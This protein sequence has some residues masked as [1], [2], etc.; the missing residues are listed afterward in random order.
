MKLGFQLFTIRDLLA[1]RA[2]WEKGI[3]ALADA[4]Y[5]AAEL[6]LFPGIDVPGI[7]A[8]CREKG[9]EVV[10]CHVAGIR[11]INDLEGLL[12]DMRAIGCRD[13]AI[14]AFPGE[15][16]RSEEGYAQ[17]AK[18]VAPV[19]AQLKAKGYYVHYH[20]H[21]F[22]FTRFPLGTAHEILLS[23]AP[24][25]LAEIDTYWA[26]KGGLHPQALIKKYAGRLRYVHFKDYMVEN[27]DIHVAPI[28]KGNLC[29]PELLAVSK[30]AGAMGIIVEQDDHFGSD[31]VAALR[32]SASFLLE[33]GREYFL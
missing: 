13:I 15:Y 2:A 20:N 8:F 4:G 5:N 22:E 12:A 1:D 27:E 23:G 21:G 24:E 18:E 31:P 14:G 32:E 3:S 26:Q 28:G 6:L 33:T 16:P 11:L 17:F 25:M 19:A 7:A 30:E 9:I 29:W 10:S